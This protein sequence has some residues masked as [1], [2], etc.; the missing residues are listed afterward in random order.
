[1]E[2]ISNNSQEKVAVLSFY[3]F[4]NIPDRAILQ[5]QILL[6]A[7][8]KYVNGTVLLAKE[9]FNG[10]IAGSL[11]NLNFVVDLIKKITGAQDISIKV[12]YCD[13]KPFSKMKVKLKNEIVA[14]KFGDLDVE[15]LKGEY[16]NSEEWSDFI[17][18]DDVVTIDTRNNYEVKIGT[19]E[20]AI[21]PETDNF[22]D[23]PQWTK[24]N[25]ELFKNK[26]VAM[27]CTGGIRCEKSTA[28]LK[29]LGVQD[30]YHLNGGIL[31]YLEDTGNKSGAWKGECFVFDDRG[32][33]SSDLQPAEGFWVEEGQTAK[34]VSLNK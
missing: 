17:K 24:D 18:R 11:E 28:L 34:S 25:M 10:S 14:L 9:G 8:R 30:V 16:I 12:N 27:F 5:P 6:A 2:D 31:Q 13:V 19:F 1:M 29:D 20:G 26:K 33:V 32:A 21:S 23:F 22:S 4:V 7:K 3:G 15:N